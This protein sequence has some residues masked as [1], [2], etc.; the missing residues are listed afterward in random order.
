MEQTRQPWVDRVRDTTRG[1]LL[2]CPAFLGQ[3]EAAALMSK[4]EARRSGLFTPALTSRSNPDRNGRPTRLSASFTNLQSVHRYSGRADRGHSLDAVPGL[5]TIVNRV[6]DE[7]SRAT[8]RRVRF[9]SVLINYY[10]TG[11]VQIGWHAD[12]IGSLA[13][14]PTIATLSLGARRKFRVRRINSKAITTVSLRTGSLAA[15]VHPFN[16]NYQHCVPAE[17]K[18]PG[19]RWSLTFRQLAE[20]SPAPPTSSAV[21]LTRLDD[22]MQA[23][24]LLAPGESDEE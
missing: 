11:R 19:A 20:I 23:Q 6:N 22:S 4:L 3:R 1:R 24:P 16:A 2:E 14:E 7:L 8:G 9:N 17:T 13:P 21:M 12:A 5:E 10:E 18:V 15:M